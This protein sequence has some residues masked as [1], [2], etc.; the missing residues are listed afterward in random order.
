MPCFAAP[1]P[2]AAAT[3]A[4]A[5]EML[6]VLPPSPPVPAVS[7]RSSR[8][9]PDD[10]RAHRFGGAGDSAGGLAFQP[11]RDEEAADLRRAS[12]PRP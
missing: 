1:A 2:A 12:P 3:S 4:A 8:G 11:Q 6:N 10:V 9:G 7:T 5:V